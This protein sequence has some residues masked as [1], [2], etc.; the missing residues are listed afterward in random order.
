[1]GTVVPHRRA[2]IDESYRFKVNDFV[3]SNE[4]VRVYSPSRRKM[5]DKNNEL[6]VKMKQ[7]FHIQGQSKPQDEMYSDISEDFSPTL[8]KHDSIFS[9]LFDKDKSEKSFSIT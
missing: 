5:R 6:F 1:M 8:K 2:E 7:I 9:R 4:V 3:S